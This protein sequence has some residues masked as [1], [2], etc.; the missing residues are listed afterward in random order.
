[1]GCEITIEEISGIPMP[2]KEEFDWS[3]ITNRE[4][5]VVLVDFRTQ[6][7]ISNAFIVPA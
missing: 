5:R 4:I 3:R 7:Y 1:M 2:L 6:E